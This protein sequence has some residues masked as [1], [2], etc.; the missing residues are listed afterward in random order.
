MHINLFQPISK[1]TI[2]ISVKPYESRNSGLHIGL[3]RKQKE[4][5]FRKRE[6]CTYFK[7]I[8]SLKES[9]RII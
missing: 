7:Y 1:I 5:V 9:E 4:F 2:N 8:C 6:T 3:R